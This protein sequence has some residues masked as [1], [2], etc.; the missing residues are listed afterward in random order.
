[1]LRILILMA[2]SLLAVF[3]CAANERQTLKGHVPEAVAQL[4]PVGR[5][6]GTQRLTLAI[7]VAP[8]DL[9]ALD[10]FVRQVSD[11]GSS[12]YRHYLTPG[13][14]AEKFGPTEKDYQA[15][16]DYVEANGLHVTRQYS[17]RVVLDVEGS[18]AAIEKTFQVTML[19]YQH[20]T[21]ART[22]YA[23]NIEPSVALGVSLLHIEGLDN[24]T[25][26][27]PKHQR[28][29]PGPDGSGGPKEGSAPG[30][31][32]WGNDFR[33]AYVPGTTLSGTGQNLGLLEFENYY[34][35]DI[36]NYEVAIGMNPANTPQLVVVTVDTPATPNDE[37]DNGEEC[38]G[39]I[40]MA[41][42]MAP[43]L[44]AIYVFE[45]GLA[46]TNP[47]FDDI[48]ESMVAYTN[49]LQFSCSWGGST[50]ADPTSE[51]LFK[52]MA[53][54]GQSF[55]DA[56]GDAGALVGNV[57]FPSDSPSITQ[58]GGT[59]MS[60]G[61]APDYPWVS[62]ICLELGTAAPVSQG[63]RAVSS[64]GGI[65]TYYGLPYWQ[66]NIS[67]AAKRGISRQCYPFPGCGR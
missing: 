62:E 25:L 2:S 31:Q 67:T 16:I 57:Q 55:Y 49:V 61:S 50:A 42:S 64:A 59:T 12:N 26:P 7:G 3:S 19:T 24:Y 53:L 20:P 15:V 41:V 40:E 39:D 10:A 52:Q 28:H 32:L 43:G 51:V 56:T 5:L 46:V 18:V 36:T 4:Q 48:F 17:N 11:P 6:D 29:S 54:Q 60:D 63:R 34:P 38:S 9:K 22:F 66:T 30:G 1:M 23:P 58:V 13:Q 27:H 33:D 37:N 45:D 65:S 47:H 14:F 44:N 8:R 35:S 21:E